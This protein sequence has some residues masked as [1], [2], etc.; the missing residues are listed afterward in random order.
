[1]KDKV[2]EET[3][4]LCPCG[5]LMPQDNFRFYQLTFRTFVLRRVNHSQN[6]GFKFFLRVNKSQNELRRQNQ[7]ISEK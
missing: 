2:P 3:V 4:A 5:E 6:V 7:I 1:M